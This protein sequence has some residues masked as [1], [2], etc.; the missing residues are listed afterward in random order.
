MTSYHSLRSNLP[1]QEKRPIPSIRD[2]VVELLHEFS[3]PLRVTRQVPADL[4]SPS[5]KNDEL[6]RERSTHEARQRASASLLERH[7]HRSRMLREG[8]VLERCQTRFD[9]PEAEPEFTSHVDRHES[10]V[11][12]LERLDVRRRHEMRDVAI[13]IS[14]VDVSDLDKI[15]LRRCVYHFRKF[16]PHQH[17]RSRFDSHE[18]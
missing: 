7:V 4:M 8:S 1:D 2:V 17:F 10:E 6:G 18:S 13:G 9:L 5:R 14:A 11:S 15:L 12:D 3:C 16:P